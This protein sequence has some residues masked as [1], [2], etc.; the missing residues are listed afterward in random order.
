MDIVRPASLDEALDAKAAMP[1]AHLL[2]GGTDFMVEVNFRHRRPSEVIG[3]RKVPELKAYGNGRIGAGVTW[4][5]IEKGP[6]R[7]FA[8]AARTVGSPQIRAAGTVGG[9]LGTASPAGDGLPYLAALDAGVELASAAR[10]TRVVQWDDFLVGVKRTSIEPD[11]LITAAVLPAQLPVADEFAKIGV[12]NAMV[13]ATVCVC[14]MRMP[15]G[16]WRIALGSVAPTTVRARNAEQLLSDTVGP[17]DSLLDE[18]AASVAAEISPITDH[19]ST[20]GYRRHAAGVLAKRL[21][22][23]CAA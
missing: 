2:A 4:R 14:V 17:S 16:T 21:V 15:D 6:Q 7:S 8:Q 11:E 12:R 18:V 5:T 13:I 20:E 19:R 9:N 3:L 1:E 22:A 23:R 10:G